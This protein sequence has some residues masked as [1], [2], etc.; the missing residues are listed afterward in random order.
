MG[1]LSKYNNSDRSFFLEGYNSNSYNVNRV[2]YDEPIIIPR[3][4]ISLLGT[5]QPQKLQRILNEADD[6]FLSRFLFAFPEAEISEE[7]ETDIDD[8]ILKH[9]FKK[10]DQLP[11]SERS[12]DLSP[13]AKTMFNQWYREHEIET[14]KQV[15]ELLQSSYGKMGGQAV[16]LACTLEHIVWALSEQKKPPEIISRDSMQKAIVLIEDYFKP[17]AKKVFT[18]CTNCNHDNALL[19]FVKHLID[20]KIQKFNV[21]TLK[22]KNA[23]P[24][25]EE[26][27]R[28][29]NFLLNLMER[30]IIRL[31]KTER[32]GRPSKDYV[33]NPK[34][35]E[36]KL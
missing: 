17:M 6:G 8:E 21:R 11:L 1:S 10:I 34:L 19:V 5:I 15:S 28:E 3:L 12:I 13:E 31:A 36:A 35:M 33:V 16:R 30:G 32:T 25:F 24:T 14:Q 23:F 27:Y 22:R 29:K 2:K 18:E 20:N 26:S 7:P 9:I 4:S